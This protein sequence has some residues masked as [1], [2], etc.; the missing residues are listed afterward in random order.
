[1]GRPVTDLKLMD[2]PNILIVNTPARPI[3]VFVT[4][5]ARGET[6]ERS[7]NTGT[8]TPSEGCRAIFVTGVD[9]GKFSINYDE[10]DPEGAI[11][12][13]EYF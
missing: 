4:S 10:A 1:M 8:Y 3:P 12:I 13:T 9:R 2:S 11:K 7:L 6:K 5:V